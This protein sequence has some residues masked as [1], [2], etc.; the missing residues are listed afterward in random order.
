MVLAPS[1]KTIGQYPAGF[2]KRR[3]VTLT[4]ARGLESIAV[5]FALADWS[6]GSD[7]ERPKE[8]NQDV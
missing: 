3:V 5:A 8:G 7:T 1:T 6:K 2:F 4:A